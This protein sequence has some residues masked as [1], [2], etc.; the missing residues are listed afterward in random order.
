MFIQPFFRQAKINA[1]AHVCTFHEPVLD[2]SREKFTDDSIYDI[3]QDISPTFND[4]MFGCQWNY[5]KVA[6]EDLFT[7]VFTSDGLC[8]SFN[9]LNSEDVYNNR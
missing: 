2:Q 9:T 7:S 4:T 6:C 1:L 8:F 3:I 5:K